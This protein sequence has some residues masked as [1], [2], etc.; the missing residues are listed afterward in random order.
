MASRG[1]GGWHL[2]RDPGVVRR[3]CCLWAPVELGVPSFAPRCLLALGQINMDLMG[4]RAKGG[5][6]DAGRLGTTRA[7]GDVVVDAVVEQD[8]VLG[9]NADLLTKVAQVK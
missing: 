8:R 4:K 9:D 2:G 7:V 1:W 5:R 3:R 6:L